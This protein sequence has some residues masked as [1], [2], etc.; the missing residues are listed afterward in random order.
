MGLGMVQALKEK[1]P[2]K[3]IVLDMLDNRLE[4]AKRFGADEVLNPKDCNAVREVLKRTDD[5]GCDIYIEA[6]GH[7]DAVQQGLDMI[8]KGGRFVEFSVM[9]GTSTVDW[10]IIG[11]AKELTIIGSQLSPHCYEP[12]IERFLSDKLKADGVVTHVFDLDHW[13][14][15]FDIA[16]SSKAL[17][18][19]ITT[20]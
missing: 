10:S 17:K 5:V 15:A 1:Q 16:A 13:K 18:V 3:L 19:V 11:D 4:L 12:V 9:S 14:E 7:P 2:K 20:R 8:R 6:T